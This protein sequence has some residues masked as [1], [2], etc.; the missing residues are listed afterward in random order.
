MIKINF[1]ITKRRIKKAD[2]LII[3]VH[4]LFNKDWKP[5]KFIYTVLVNED[6]KVVKDKV[7]VDSNDSSLLEKMKQDKDVKEAINQQIIV[8][9][10]VRMMEQSKEDDIVITRERFTENQNFN[11][12]SIQFMLKGLDY[13]IFEMNFYKNEK[14][15]P[16][17]IY[18]YVKDI[19]LKG[20][21]EKRL[22]E[23]ARGK[24]CKQVLMQSTQKVKMLTKGYQTQY[25]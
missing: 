20:S 19:N 1:L 12:F 22:E 3:K 10:L 25:K 9:N 7:K 16:T 14:R 6:G 17:I 13:A 5:K 23:K 11:I 4:G 2:R 18:N 24:L 15:L 8:W 21:I